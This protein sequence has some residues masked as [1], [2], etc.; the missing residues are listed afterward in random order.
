[1]IGGCG[2]ARQRGAKRF[3][4]VVMV[5]SNNKEFVSGV[6]ML[7]TVELSR[8]L[9]G[10]KTWSTRSIGSKNIKVFVCPQLE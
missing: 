4:F 5:W 3:L 1:M 2:H 8:F 10:V 9:H 7:G 6:V